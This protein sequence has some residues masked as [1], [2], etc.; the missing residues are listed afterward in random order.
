MITAETVWKPYPLPLSQI[1]DTYSP[2]I[3]WKSLL[4]FEFWESIFFLSM[5]LHL[6][7]ELP[8]PSIKASSLAYTSDCQS[9]LVMYYN[10]TII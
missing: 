6:A 4:E 2:C 1:R 3:V 5:N 9:A 8:L 10:A 7:F